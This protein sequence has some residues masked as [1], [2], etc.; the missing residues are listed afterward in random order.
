MA[1]N[2][3]APRWT[4]PIEVPRC[5]PGWHTGPPDFVGVGAQRSGTSWWYRLIEA[6]PRAARVEGQSKELH[7][8]GRFWSGDVPDDLESRYHSFFPRPPGALTGEWTPRYMYDFWSLRLLRRAAPEA[9]LLVLLRDPVER[10]RS[11]VARFMRR[12]AKVGRQIDLMMFADAV[13]RGFYHLQLKRLFEVFPP[14]QVL[15]QQYERCTRDT[16][17]ELEQT[18]RFLGLEP[19]AELPQRARTRERPPNEKPALSVEMRED[20]VARLEDDVRRL[21]ELCP[22]IDLWLWRNFAHLAEPAM[23]SV[24]R[25]AAG[26]GAR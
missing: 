23:A 5:P 24:P 15:V 22:Q 11:G 9:K 16:A 4:K 12:T 20:L 3:T 1:K 7:Y 19:F 6:H 13:H 17:A 10:Y 18:C 25:A 14:E 21:V 26:G 8:F 2:R